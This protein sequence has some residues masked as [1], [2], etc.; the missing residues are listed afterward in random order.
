MRRRQDY[1]PD[2]QL[3]HDFSSLF[4][5]LLSREDELLRIAIILFWREKLDVQ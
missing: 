5:L 4:S 3:T 1:S 2:N